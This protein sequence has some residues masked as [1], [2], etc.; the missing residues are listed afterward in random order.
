MTVPCLINHFTSLNFIVLNANC[1]EIVTCSPSLGHA[2]L[3]FSGVW[4]HS[5]FGSYRTRMVDQRYRR[6]IASGTVRSDFII[7]LKP[8]FHFSAC[9]VKAHEPVGVHAFRSELAVEA[10]N[11]GIV[12][13]FAW[14]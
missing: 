2:D 10:F 5:S 6:L 14:S 7:V 8:S 4:G 1:F 9:V 11:K 13:W 3:E 12:S